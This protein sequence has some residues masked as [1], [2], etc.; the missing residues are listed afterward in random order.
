MAKLPKA[1]QAA[2]KR[3][4]DIIEQNNKQGETED[5]NSD[6]T[7]LDP[8]KENEPEKASEAVPVK[9]VDK[10]GDPD[11]WERRF[12]SAQ[13]MFDAHKQKLNSE[14]DSLKQQVEALTEQLSQAKKAE[15]KKLDIISEE[16]RN[17]FDED[18]LSLIERAAI[19]AAQLA[20]EEAREDW[21]ASIKPIESKLEKAEK[22]AQQKA[23]GLFWAELEA[24]VPDFREINESSE[25]HSW[26]A[27]ED[28]FSGIQ[29]QQI[30][31]NAQSNL[32]SKKVIK[33]FN[34]FKKE[35]N[36]ESKAPRNNLDAK[37]T[38]DPSSPSETSVSAP[39]AIT[40]GDIKRHFDMKV[41]MKGY[42]G[43]KECEEMERKINRAIQAGR[44]M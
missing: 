34:V 38:P 14:V 28:D 19:K 2:A 25:F 10:E 7:T 37:V 33:L 32:D 20:K 27:G 9:A 5:T 4:N 36:V 42:K 24:G 30:L 8:P 22:D 18:T 17:T 21:E 13:G 26:L 43:S 31:S 6:V 23:E 11:Y 29:R 15:P 44:V 41:R 3:A 1:V 35:F 16:D 12:K 39:E 40:K